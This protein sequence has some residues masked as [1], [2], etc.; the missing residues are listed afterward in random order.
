[1]SIC[2]GPR[3]ACTIRSNTLSVVDNGRIIQLELAAAANS[4]PTYNFLDAAERDS[5]IITPVE[6]MEAYL[7][8]PNEK[9][10]YNGTAW[11][12]IFKARTSFTPNMSTTGITVGLGTLTCWYSRDGD[13]VH[14][15]GRFIFG[16]GSGVIG[17]VTI[18]LPV[19]CAN[20]NRN[21]GAAAIYDAAT[22]IIYDVQVDVF[23]TFMNVYFRSEGT[24]YHISSSSPNP[25]WA[26]PDEFWWNVSYPAA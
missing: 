23:T 11:R 15:N 10:R 21:V 8:T 22:N 9:S 20:S 3:C 14:Y 1:M 6:G 2:G 19:N 16:A 5:Q 12:T 26:A 18:P 7:R 17:M 13:E 24:A 25:A 4:F